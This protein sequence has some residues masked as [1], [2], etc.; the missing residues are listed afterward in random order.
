MQIGWKWKA[1]DGQIKN[2]EKPDS[3]S[4][5]AGSKLENGSLTQYFISLVWESPN[6][7]SAIKHWNLG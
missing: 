2:A 6:G 7:C 1:T 4:M 5:V 3:N